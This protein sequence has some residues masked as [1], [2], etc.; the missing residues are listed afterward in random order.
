MDNAIQVRNI[1]IPWDYSEVSDTILYD[2]ELICVKNAPNFTGQNLQVMGDGVHKGPWLISQLA[3]TPAELQASLTA[4]ITARKNADTAFQTSLDAEA[5]ARKNADEA[6]QRSL[7]EETQNRQQADSA[8]AGMTNAHDSTCTP[9]SNRIAMYDED[10]GLHSD[11]VPSADNDVVRKTE[12]DALKHILLDIVRGHWLITERAP[13]DP[14][15]RVTERE[16][17]PRRRERA[18]I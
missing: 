1:F 10:K 8:H 18:I 11:K 3:I 13:M 5:A 2:G 9:A 12:L 14:M 7:A 6:F 4:E 16:G 15:I 17:T